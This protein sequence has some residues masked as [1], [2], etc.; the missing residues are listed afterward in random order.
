MISDGHLSD[1]PVI[2]GMWQKYEGDLNF[3]FDQRESKV[4]IHMAT[5]LL[6]P[7]HPLKSNVIPVTPQ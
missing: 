7:N 2:N 5:S 1:F 3:A 4:N 6:C